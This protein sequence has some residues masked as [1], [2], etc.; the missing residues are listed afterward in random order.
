MKIYADHHRRGMADWP[1]HRDVAMGDILSYHLSNPDEALAYAIRL[2]H[3]SMIWVFSLPPAAAHWK[4]FCARR[5]RICSHDRRRGTK[6]GTVTSNAG[7]RVSI[8]NPAVGVGHHR[9]VW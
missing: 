2:L 6:I 5:R 1:D 7:L 8:R 9:E 3:D 4:I